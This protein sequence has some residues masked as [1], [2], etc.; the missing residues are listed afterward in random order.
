MGPLVIYLFAI[1]CT[2]GSDLCVCGSGLRLQT[3]TYRPAAGVRLVRVGLGARLSANFI[4]RRLLNGL[5]YQP[6]GFCL[7]RAFCEGCCFLFIFAYSSFHEFLLRG[8]NQHF[9]RQLARD[10]DSV[11]LEVDLLAALTSYQA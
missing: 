8:I 11:S 2:V 4:L 9:R 10:P 3:T 7:W 1:A 6:I 5:V